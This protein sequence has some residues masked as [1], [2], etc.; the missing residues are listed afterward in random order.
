LNAVTDRLL[1]IDD[2]AAEW[3]VGQE[4]IRR[5]IRD[6]GLPFV[7]IGRSK[8]RKPQYRF[9]RSAVDRWLADRERVR[10]RPE[11]APTPAPAGAAP[12][13]WDGK[14]RLRRGPA[15]GGGPNRSPLA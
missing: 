15:R 9:R 11:A 14:D 10:E 2:L 12:P 6:D 13:G 1:T 7:P 3:S 8:G 4:V 5:H